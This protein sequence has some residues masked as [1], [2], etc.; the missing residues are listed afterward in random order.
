MDV[1]LMARPCARALRLGVRVLALLRVRR[2]RRPR[3]TRARCWSSPAPPGRRTPRQ[4]RHRRRDQGARRRP[5]TSPSTSRE[6]GATINAGEPRRLPRGRVRQ[7]RRRRARRRAGGRAAGLRPGAAAASSAS[8]RRA[9]LEEGGAAFF[10]TLT[11]PHRPRAHRH[12][13]GEQRRTSSSS[14]ACT[15]RRAQLA[16][17]AEGADRELVHVDHQPDGHG[18]HRRA[19][20]RRTS[21]PGR[22]VDHQRR[23]PALHR[24]DG[25]A[26]AAAQ[27]PASWCRDVQQG[28]SFYTELGA[29]RAAGPTPSSRSTSLGAIQ[30]AAGMV[31]GGCKAASTPT[32]RRPASRRRTRPAIEHRLRTAR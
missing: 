27:A 1:S 31:R 20:A 14:T 26:P 24:R 3:R 7:L 5:A 22:H 13:R 2:A 4:R 28:R 23:R 8:A 17:G 6:R 16:A 12:R 30:W 32:T 21:L 10:D 18:P 19:R 9:L 25:H 11:R 29:R 15:R